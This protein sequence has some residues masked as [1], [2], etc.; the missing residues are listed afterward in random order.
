MLKSFLF[1]TC[2][3]GG[4]LCADLTIGIVNFATCVTESKAGKAEQSGLEALQKQIESHL[5]KADKELQEIANKFSDSEYMDGLSPEAEA[6][7]K[8]KAQRLS[9]E[10]GRLRNQSYQIVN[11]ANMKLVQQ[12]SNLISEASAEVAKEKKL[13]LVVHKDICFFYDDTLDVTSLVIEKMNASYKG[14]SQ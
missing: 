10:N 8:E 14:P 3:L 9:E 2:A 13:S 6:S 1:L 4:T 12:L 7:L 5:E 11:Q